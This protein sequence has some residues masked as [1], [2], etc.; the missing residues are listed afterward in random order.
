MTLLN[1]MIS[2]AKK[3]VTVSPARLAWL[4]AMPAA[5]ALCAAAR[6]QAPGA[7]MSASEASAGFAAREADI[8]NRKAWAEY[9]YREA[10]HDCY[11]KFF[12]NWCIDRAKDKR[13]TTMKAIR[14]D[15]LAL[16]S[17]ERALRASQREQRL[18]DKRTQDAAQ[19]PQREAEH[20]QNAADY[21]AKQQAHARQASDRASQAAQREANVRAYNAKQAAHQEKL[22]QD[23]ADAAQK[24]TARAENVQKYEQK[25]SDAAA[26]AKQIEERRA[27]GRDNAIPGAPGQ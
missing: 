16:D 10:E 1:P 11:D 20:R 9:H 12:V 3:I 27:K 8:G 2:F 15:E 17:E 6:A 24:A 25:Q 4:W 18:A 26:R 21:Q 13:R 22:R 7:P 19:A 14:A 23:Q 5:L